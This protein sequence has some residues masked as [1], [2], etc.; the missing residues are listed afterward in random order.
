[1]GRNDN[2]DDPLKWLRN[3]N[4]SI[5]QTQVVTQ[6]LPDWKKMGWRPSYNL[7]SGNVFTRTYYRVS[8][9]PFDWWY[10]LH[11][12]ALFCMLQPLKSH[13]VMPW[14]WDCSAFHARS[15]FF[16]LLK[17]KFLVFIWMKFDLN[18]KAF[19]PFLESLFQ[20]SSTY[21]W[22]RVC[23][24]PKEH[25]PPAC[26]PPLLRLSVFSWIFGWDTWECP[27]LCYHLWYAALTCQKTGLA[28]T[29][30][31][32]SQRNIHLGRIVRKKR[33]RKNL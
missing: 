2:K 14:K 31:P 11:L 5:T 19:R 4:T 16:S 22:F 1:M 13:G 18:F 25:L 20:V 21:S 8:K 15:E 33:E 7:K 9:S 6:P 24:S 28:K 32:A 30:S 27:H 17:V 26:P 23:H 10:W 12:C 29:G 3:F